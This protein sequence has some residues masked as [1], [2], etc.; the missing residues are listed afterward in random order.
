MAAHSSRRKST[1]GSTSEGSRQRAADAAMENQRKIQGI[2]SKWGTKDNRGKQ[3]IE[4]ENLR[5]WLAS[6]DGGEPSED[7]VSWIVAIANS[8]HAAQNGRKVRDMARTT[9]LSS[10]VERALKAWLTYQDAKPQIE[11]MFE[12]F[13]EDKNNRMEKAELRK[14]LAALN[15]GIEPSDHELDE[16]MEEADSIGHGAISKPDIVKAVSLWYGL[17]DARRLSSTGNVDGLPLAEVAG[18]GGCTASK[19]CAIQ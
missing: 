8:P 19:T 17:E 5:K 9:I 1:V 12:Q 16:V 10:D 7:E 4:L 3:E 18:G 15:G 6:E 11:K 2:V 13:D 14:M